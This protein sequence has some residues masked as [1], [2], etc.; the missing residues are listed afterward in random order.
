MSYFTD[1]DPGK[2]WKREE[3][4]KREEARKRAV[5]L[6]KKNWKSQHLSLGLTRNDLK[7]PASRVT[8]ASSK[9]SFDPSS[10]LPS[11]PDQQSRRA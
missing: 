8:G 6:M 10:M 2:A 4:L 3:A 11:G 1:D 7:P 5:A 9:F